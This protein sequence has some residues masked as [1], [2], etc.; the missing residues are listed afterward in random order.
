MQKKE[1]IKKNLIAPSLLSVAKNKILYKFN[2]KKIKSLQIF[3]NFTRN[4]N[5]LDTMIGAI[6]GR[7]I[8]INSVIAWSHL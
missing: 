5:I 7:N 1:I 2:S 4:N 6:Y 3:E 8:Q